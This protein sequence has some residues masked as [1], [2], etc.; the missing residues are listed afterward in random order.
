MSAASTLALASLVA[1]VSFAACA[2]ALLLYRSLRRLSLEVA[3][4]RQTLL[5][6]EV[7][8]EDEDA[9][10]EVAAPVAPAVMGVCPTIIEEVED[11]EE[12]KPTV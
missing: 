4:L 6:E 1:A 11:D 10:Q 12:K 5:G 7:Q 9:E 2:A 8:E 3:D